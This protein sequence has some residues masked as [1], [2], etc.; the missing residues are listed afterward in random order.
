MK[1]FNLCKFVQYNDKQ[2]LVVIQLPTRFTQGNHTDK[3]RSIVLHC[4]PRNLI[5]PYYMD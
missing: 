5:Y 4:T 2:Q 3:M 1:C